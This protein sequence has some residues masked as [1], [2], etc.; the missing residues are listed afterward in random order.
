MTASPPPDAGGSDRLRQAIR[1]HPGDPALHNGL[2]NELLARG[3][4]AGAIACYDA[5]LLLAPNLAELHYNRANALVAADQTEAAMAAFEQA[6]AIDPAHAGAYQNAGNLLRRLHRPEAAAD[7]YRRALR[8][9]PAD[10]AVRYNLGVVLLDLD[11]TA[12]ALTWFEQAATAAIPYPAAF[13]SAGEALLRLGRPEPALAWFAGA[14][15]HDPVSQPAHFGHGVA[16]L[17]LGAWRQ[18]WAEFEWRLADP[19]IAIALP[20]TGVPAWTGIQPVAGR[21]LLLRAEQGNGDSIQF[22]RYAPLLRARG[23]RVVLQVQSGLVALFADLADQAIAQTTPPP[24]CDLHCSLMS[25]PHAFA[26]ELSTV[27]T[28]PYLAPDP[29]RLAAWRSRLG[30][31][32]GPRIGLAWSGN[33][34]HMLDHQRSIPAALLTPLLAAPNAGF[35]LL[36]PDIKPADHPVPATIATHFADLHDFA[37]TAAL[38]ALMDLVITVDTSVAHLAGALGRPVWI[39]LPFAAD[40]RWLRDRADSPWYPSARLFR[41]TSPGDWAPVIA[42]ITAALAAFCAAVP[43]WEHSSHAAPHPS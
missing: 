28:D 43:S 41:Q 37:D 15:R 13:A 12:E 32:P 33:P 31:L 30:D 24:A 18:G 5:A 22:V 21:T 11:R 19:R 6:L 36:Q 10:A 2:G 39:M 34:G 26:T 38:I 29:S 16:L 40:F 3:D 9:T 8:L 4:P 25:L 14:L 23:A 7:F 1:Q 20:E 27:P 35:H 42:E 17:T